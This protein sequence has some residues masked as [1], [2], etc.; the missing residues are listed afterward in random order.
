MVADSAATTQSR[1]L[2]GPMGGSALERCPDCAATDFV[3]V[4]DW[5]RADFLCGECHAQWRVQHGW[6]FR[7][8]PER[9]PSDSAGVG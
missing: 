4:T 8:A 7:V 5:Y 1:T 3:V 9:A 6:V 2:V